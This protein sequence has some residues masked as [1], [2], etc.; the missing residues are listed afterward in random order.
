MTLQNRVILLF[1]QFHGLF[2]CTTVFVL[3]VQW[4]DL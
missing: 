4:H 2:D 1:Q 3:N